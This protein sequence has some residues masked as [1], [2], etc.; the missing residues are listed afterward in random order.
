[1]TQPQTP[2]EAFEHWRSQ[3][4]NFVFLRQPINRVFLEYTRQDVHDQAA[5]V[6]S[7]LQQSGLKPGDHVAILSKNCAHW[8]MA[9]LAI[10]MGGFVSVPIYPTL[11]RDT[12]HTIL[13]H[14]ET[15]AI[16]VAKLDDYIKQK[17]GIP[18]HMV[19]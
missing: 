1:M 12:I 14:S 19:R 16:I 7:S 6:A 10:M 5:A 11:D 13:T 15:K 4:P 9:D 3:D 2:L 18:E 17:H 8:F